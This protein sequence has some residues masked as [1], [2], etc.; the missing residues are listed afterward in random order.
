MPR[1]SIKSQKTRWV[2]KGIRDRRK[3]RNAPS[4][5]QI[6]RLPA[7]TS[8]ASQGDQ[9]AFASRQRVVLRYAA[10]LE[11]MGGGT[12]VGDSSVFRANSI[13]D[14]DFTGTG[15]KAMASDQWGAMYFHY[16]VLRARITVQFSQNDGSSV[17]ITCWV[18]LSST[19][20][21][22]ANAKTAI[23]QGRCAWKTIGTFG[24]DNAE[25]L[26]S[27]Y[28]GK[29]FFGPTF[30]DA[31]HKATF[32]TSPAEDVYFLVSYQPTLATDVGV[33]VTGLVL[34]EYDCELTE[35]KNLSES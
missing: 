23:E 26:V 3:A 11:G 10:R 28:D 5:N 33:G 15:H 19:S 27:V 22:T 8:V 25:P 29:Q 16:K 7:R 12:G 9:S 21:A 13:Y 17:P 4:R 20:T 31:D 30:I 32:T 18:S 34:I 35:P 14:P 6:S 2:P 24:N 1:V